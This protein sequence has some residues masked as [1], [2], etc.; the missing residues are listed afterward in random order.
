MWVKHNKAGEKLV[1]NKTKKLKKIIEIQKH[2]N[3]TQVGHTQQSREKLVLNK[4]EKQKN[5]Q[6]QKYKITK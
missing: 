5:I 3:T 4:N 6:I 1:L 2:K